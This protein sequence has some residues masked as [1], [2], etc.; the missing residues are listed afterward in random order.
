MNFSQIRVGDRFSVGFDLSD[1][2]P[3]T[4]DLTFLTG[5][6]VSVQPDEIMLLKS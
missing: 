4:E 2:D 1:I 5:E 6:V 3:A